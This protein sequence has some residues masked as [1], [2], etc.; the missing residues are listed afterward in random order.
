MP[1]NDIENMVSL[2]FELA[3]PMQVNDGV[4]EAVP[5][6]PLID[7]HIAYRTARDYVPSTTYIGSI[8]NLMETIEK[9]SMHY[10]VTDLQAQ[11]A[12]LAVE[13]LR[14]QIP[15]IRSGQT[16]SYVNGS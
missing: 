4:H 15:F 1:R 3:E 11:L 9:A 7:P 5:T 12:D 16:R 6:V 10:R 13:G 2:G 8:Y 14:L